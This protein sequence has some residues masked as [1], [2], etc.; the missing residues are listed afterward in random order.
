MT[1]H[2]L[3]VC[4]APNVICSRELTVRAALEARAAISVFEL[5]LTQGERLLLEEA[6]LGAVGPDGALTIVPPVL[7]AALAC[8]EGSPEAAADP[9]LYSDLQQQPGRVGE[10]IRAETRVSTLKLQV[11]D[12]RAA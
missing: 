10:R 2:N 11:S 6:P 12:R 7:D 8:L 4:W 5:M 3:S 1:P 9:D